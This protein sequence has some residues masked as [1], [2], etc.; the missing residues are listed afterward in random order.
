MRA[1]YDP[2]EGINAGT[3]KKAYVESPLNPP[4]WFEPRE[5]WEIAFADITLS[6]T[7]S[8]AL[9][10]VSDERGLRYVTT[11]GMW[12]KKAKSSLVCASHAS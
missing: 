2:D 10:L 8:A 6:P 1:F 12:K 7:Y 11:I 9:G 4:V 3:T 5:V